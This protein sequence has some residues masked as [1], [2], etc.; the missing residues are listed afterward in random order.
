[1]SYGPRRQRVTK[2]LM[3][4]LDRHGAAEVLG[5]TTREF[6]A[7]I[8]N[9]TFPTPVYGRPPDEEWEASDIAV[10]AQRLEWYDP[11]P[12]TAVVAHRLGRKT[13]QRQARVFCGPVKGGSKNA[14]LARR[15]NP[16]CCCGC[17]FLN[18]INT[19]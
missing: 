7:L 9:P 6:R 17:D 15:P 13:H 12:S 16:R 10:F 8:R 1:M 14:D 3:K 19:F 18:R 4:I 11:R 2:R 5:V